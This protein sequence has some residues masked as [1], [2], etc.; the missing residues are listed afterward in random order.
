MHQIPILKDVN[1]DQQNNGLVTAIDIDRDTAYRLGITMQMIDDTL[2]DSF[3]QRQISIMF[4]QR[5]QY[6]VVLEVFLRYKENQLLLTTFI[7][8]LR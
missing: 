1:T 6:R 7:L 3:G 2:Y 5:N 4:T 8:I